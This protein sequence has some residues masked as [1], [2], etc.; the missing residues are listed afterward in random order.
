MEIYDFY[1]ISSIFF[2]V[3]GQNRTTKYVLIA[4]TIGCASL[5]L[6]MFIL[7]GIGLY[8]MAKRS[9]LKKKGLAFVPFANIWYIGKLAG[10]CN[11]FG[12]KMKRAGLYAMIAQI[13]ATVLCGLVIAAQMYLYLKFGVEDI[14]YMTTG[15]SGFSLTVAKFYDISSYF[16]SIAQLVARILTVILMS[17]LYKKYSPRNYFFLGALTFMLP[18]RYIAIFA[19]RN[20]TPIDY[21]AYMRARHEAYMR[22]Q[23][24]YYNNTYGNPYGNPYNQNSNGSPYGNPY[25]GS[26]GNPYGNPYAGQTPPRPEPPE[27]PFAEFSSDKKSDREK[28]H[29]NDPNSDGFFD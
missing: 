21:E 6:A 16:L 9:G 3:I 25:G 2:E 11:V 24:Q 27:D 7:Q 18:A 22:R 8:V 12:Q 19:L 28:P 23:Q 13:I 17:G 20:R 14:Y 26:Y 15:L 29:E 4:S 10:E 1:L 5:L